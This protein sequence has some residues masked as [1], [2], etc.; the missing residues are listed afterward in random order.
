MKKNNPLI[1]VLFAGIFLIQCSNNSTGPKLPELSEVIL[2]EEQTLN[3]SGY[4]PL[5]A[6]ITIETN[7][8]VKINIEVEGKDEES[9]ISHSFNELNTM[10]EIPVLGL[11]ADYFNTVRLTFSTA[12][13]DEIG[14]KEYNFQTATLSLAMPEVEIDVANISQMAEGWT[15]V[16]YFGYA[17]GGS[18]A[19]QRPLMFDTNGEVRWHIDYTDHPTLNHLFY[20]DGMERLQNGN[21]YFGDGSTNKI[22]EINMLGEVLNNWDMPGYGFHHQ[23]L[24]KPDGNFIVT[25]NKFGEN[26]IED[27]LIE[28][29][30]EQNQ[31]V[32][33]WNLKE[34][35]QYSRRALTEDN[36]DWFHANAVA[37]SE[38]DDCI[39]VSGRTQGLVKLTADNEVVWIMGPHLDWGNSGRGEDLNQYLLQPLAADDNPIT[40]QDV[41]DGYDNHPDFEWNWYQHAPQIM[42]NGNIMLFD[43]GDNRN[44]MGVG[45]YSRA[46]EYE[47][48][49]SE[50][51][52]KQVWEYGKKRGAE[53][54]SRIVSDIDYYSGADHVF[55]S[56]GAVSNSRTYGKVV[57]V[58]YLSKNVIFEATMI[59]PKSLY[60]ITFHRTERMN[61]YPDSE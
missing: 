55:F 41:L 10:H 49:E 13:G 40:N 8:P 31:I 12:D 45:P 56:P 26:T 5:T 1:I 61:I 42:P 11:Y 52:I 29:D 32:N 2:S 24:E 15:F 50:M 25:V 19:P 23:V 17:V 33:V 9:G 27:Y 16:S 43:N 48:N 36:T 22:Y 53:T 54:Y 34:S 20:D 30:R 3:P 51:T 38:E 7:I 4:A 28:I 6:E 21:L 14:K 18:V 39:I 47:V 57:E 59:P 35:L 46:V 37:Y 44:F 60:I 58:D